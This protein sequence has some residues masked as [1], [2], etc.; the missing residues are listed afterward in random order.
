MTTKPLIF[1]GS[2]SNLSILA[3]TAENMGLAV[4]GVLDDNYFGNTDS[5]CNVPFIG[6]EGTFDF[7]KERDNYLFFVSPSVVP[8]NITDRAKRLKMIDIVEKYNLNSAKII[9]KY[10]EISRGAIL[11]PGCYV[12]FGSGVGFQTVLMPHSQVHAHVALG[13]HCVLSKNSVLERGSIIASGITIGENVHIGFGAAVA[14]AKYVG[15]NSVVHPRV[16]VFRDVEENEIVNI[17]GNN[18]RRVYRDVIRT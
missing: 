1:L 12:G 2:N 18:T 17:A 9:H 10:T 13:H 14:K 16:T 5:I 4:K 7:G 8:I 6:S 11:Y 3:E 15:N